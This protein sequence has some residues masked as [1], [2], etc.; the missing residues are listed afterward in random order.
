MVTC[1]CMSRLA[2]QSKAWEDKCTPVEITYFPNPFVGNFCRPTAQTNAGS[3]PCY[4]NLCTTGETKDM[5]EVIGEKMFE[6]K[7]IIIQGNSSYSPPPIKRVGRFSYPYLMNSTPCIIRQDPFFLWDWSKEP[8]S[9]LVLHPSTCRS[10]SCL[11]HPILRFTWN[12]LNPFLTFC[13]RISSSPEHPFTSLRNRN[14]AVCN[15]CMSLPLITQHSF[16][17]IRTG[18]VTTSLGCVCVYSYFEVLP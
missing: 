3:H 6:Q 12:I 5:S 4:P 1:C 9:V 16:P 8:A 14:S 15:L 10:Q 11:H 2:S 18:K 7:R 17:Y 13:F